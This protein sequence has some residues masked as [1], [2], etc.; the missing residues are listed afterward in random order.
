MPSQLMN[1]PHHHQAAALGSAALLLLVEI[2]RKQQD[3]E[4]T[5]IAERAA[6][7]GMGHMSHQRHE[8]FQIE[9]SRPPNYT[10]SDAQID[11]ILDEMVMGEE[12]RRQQ[13]LNHAHPNQRLCILP[14]PILVPIPFPLSADF[15]TKHY[16]L[17]PSKFTKKP[18]NT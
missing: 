14:I 3:A 6:D 12:S 16:G 7:E 18:I 2:F 5:R 10:E 15:I 1:G 17:Q 4:K 9:Y 13:E 11:R 8:Q